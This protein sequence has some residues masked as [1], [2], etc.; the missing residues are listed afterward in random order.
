MVDY[1][2]FARDYRSEYLTDE[3]MKAAY[4]RRMKAEHDTLLTPESS[5]WRRGRGRRPT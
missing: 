3:A 4:D 2:Q 1:G 5:S